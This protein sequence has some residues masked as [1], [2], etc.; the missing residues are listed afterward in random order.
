VAASERR[1]L[2]DE[3]GDDQGSDDQDGDDQIGVSGT[4]PCGA[5]LPPNTICACNCVMIPAGAGDDDG[6]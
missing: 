3:D 6:C 1:A 2:D 5:P 4:Q